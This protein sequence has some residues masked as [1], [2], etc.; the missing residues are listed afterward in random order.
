M[1]PIFKLIAATGVFAALAVPGV[2]L[3]AGE[4]PKPP[5]KPPSVAAP[6]AAAPAAAVPAAPVSSVPQTT[7]AAYGDWLLRCERVGEPDKNQ[8]LC[9]IAETLQVQGQGTVAQIAFSRAAAAGQLRVVTLLP[10]NVALPGA[11]SLAIDDK[12]AQPI[13]LAWRRC[14][15]GGCLADGDMKDETQKRWRALTER[16]EIR[17]KNSGGQ[18][19]VL[20]FSFRGF[21]QAVDALLKQ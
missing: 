9:E 17:W 18:D 7:T 20:P 1:R 19:V 3:A 11:V 8:R 12:D 2:L 15:P 13:E 16:G 14:L 21:S 6:A 4:A 10:V 5:P